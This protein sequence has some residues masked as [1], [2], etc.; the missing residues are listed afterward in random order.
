MGVT[1]WI[2]VSEQLPK[3]VEE[4]KGGYKASDLVL[5]LLPENGMT[6]GRYIHDSTDEEY[7]LNDIGGFI[8]RVGLVT[9]WHE[10]PEPPEK[11]FI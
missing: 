2:R 5:I 8:Y 4:T 10:L 1:N 3:W 7:W 6:I 11:Q 9:H